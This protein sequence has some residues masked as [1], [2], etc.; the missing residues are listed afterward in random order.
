MTYLERLAD[1]R[2]K[3]NN[4]R[5]NK[6]DGKAWD[7]RKAKGAKRYD[8]RGEVVTRLR[9]IEHKA[10]WAGLETFDKAM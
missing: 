8:P 4:A 7:N 6:K 5:L 10:R 3:F 9:A 1:T 2:V